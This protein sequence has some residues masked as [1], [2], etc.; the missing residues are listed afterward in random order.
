MVTAIQ[1]QILQFPI[2]SLISSVSTSVTMKLDDTNYLTWH[3]QMQLL[4]EGHGIM[5]FVDGSTPCPPRFLASKFGDSEP[6]SGQPSDPS[7]VHKES[8][9]YLVWRMHDRAL[10][11]LITAT[12]SPPV[13]SCAIGSTSAR[14]LWTRLKE[15]FSTVTRT[16]I[17]LKDLRSQ[18]L[19]EEAMIETLNTAPMINALVAQSPKPSTFQSQSQ[20]GRP[21]PSYNTNPGYKSFTNKNKGRFN[22]TTRFRNVAQSN[23]CQICGNPNHSA[24]FYFQKGSSSPMT[25]MYVNHKSDNSTAPPL[26][27]ALPQQVWITDTGATNH[28]TTDLSNL[29]LAT[30]YHSHESIQIANG[31]NHMEDFIQRAVQ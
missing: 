8:D 27:F 28:M 12:L 9:D 20:S 16:T 23:G 21:Y 1:L 14:D 17:S 24:E 3:F 5:G 18:L 4:L 19:V 26:P 11:Q 13:I 6:S 15:Q 31:Q 10:M 30:P 2:T 7:C 22:S 25:A 29:S